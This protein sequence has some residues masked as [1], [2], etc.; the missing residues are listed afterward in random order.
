MEVYSYELFKICNVY[1][2]IS[3]TSPL[4]CMN[5]GA[6][7]KRDK[8]EAPKSPKSFS[9]QECPIC[10]ESLNDKSK[11]TLILHKGKIEHTFHAACILPN[12]CPV[13]PVPLATL[14]Q[15]FIAMNTGKHE[16]ALA[17]VYEFSPEVINQIYK[18]STVLIQALQAV[19]NPE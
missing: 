11:P 13:C 8:K 1:C 12:K 14:E 19:M 6:E 15:Y 7:D 4:F 17:M 9:D 2:N 16:E 3:F 5:S 10:M 18:D